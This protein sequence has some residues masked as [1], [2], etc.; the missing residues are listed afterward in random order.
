MMFLSFPLFL[1][2]LG[3]VM[4]TPLIKLYEV[5]FA[6]EV[7]HI[8]KIPEDFKGP[9]EGDTLYV[10]DSPSGIMYYLP[11]LSTGIVRWRNNLSRTMW[12]GPVNNSQSFLEVQN[13]LN[14]FYFVVRHV[15]T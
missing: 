11:N 10:T 12:L 4:L 9:V 7:Y 6:K 8:K 2:S 5:W 1:N 3:T 14:R 13:M 15:R